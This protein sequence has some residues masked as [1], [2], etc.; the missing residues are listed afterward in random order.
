MYI[1]TIIH[2]ARVASWFSKKDPKKAVQPAVSGDAHF[3]F[4]QY[5][6]VPNLSEM[7]G[8]GPTRTIDII[9]PGAK[10]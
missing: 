9:T 3:V 8:P 6:T 4:R 2:N 7:A 1:E 5:N 10:S